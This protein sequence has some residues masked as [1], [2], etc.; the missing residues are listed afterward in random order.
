MWSISSS[1]ADAKVNWKVVAHTGEK[2]EE[3]EGGYTTGTI[4]GTITRT[5]GKEGKK[6]GDEVKDKEG[7]SN[8]GKG[9]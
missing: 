8:E 9:N 3:G 4:T 7:D 5:G 6:K 1:R 2:Q